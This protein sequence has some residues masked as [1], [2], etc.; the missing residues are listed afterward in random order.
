MAAVDTCPGEDVFVAFIAGELATPETDQL[1]AHMD[2]CGICAELLAQLARSPLVAV[3]SDADTR[4][5]EPPPPLPRRLVSGETVGRYVIERELG[6]GGM[7]VV[8]ADL[9]RKV[10]VKLLRPRL[11]DGTTG[12]KRLLAEARTLAAL[13]HENVVQVFSGR[14]EDALEPLRRG[15]TLIEN[16]Y[17]ENEQLVT[18]L[19]GLGEALRDLGR[20]G[21]S[22]EVYERAVAIGERVSALHLGSSLRGRAGLH[23]DAGAPAKAEPLL[24]RAVQVWTTMEGN[25]PALEGYARFDLARA[26]W[27]LDRRGE[28][29]AEARAALQLLVATDEEFHTDVRAWLEAR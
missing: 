13:S 8:Y 24:R 14:P 3:R 21:E 19:N 1:E 11:A 26:L 22:A 23:L 6:A 17:G 28:A 27:D 7:G 29:R 15:A 20:L 12:H 18:V 4:G 2:A 16:T 10:A 5:A 25:D 9:D